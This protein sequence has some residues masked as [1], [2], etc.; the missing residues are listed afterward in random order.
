MLLRPGCVVAGDGGNRIQQFL[1]EGPGAIHLFQAV[2][3]YPHDRAMSLFYSKPCHIERI[4]IFYLPSGFP[5]KI[6]AFGFT[7]IE[8]TESKI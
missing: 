7:F 4:Y 8:S 6:L 1:P 5:T 2:A 3:N